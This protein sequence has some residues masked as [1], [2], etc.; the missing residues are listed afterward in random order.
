M[1][2]GVLDLDLLLRLAGA[3]LAGLA[4][5]FPYRTRPGG[6]LTHLFVTVGAAVFG[7]TATAMAQERNEDLLRV[8]QGVA[9]GIGFVGAASVLKRGGTIAGIST[10][11][12]IWIAAAVGCQAAF[13]DPRLAV[14]L[15]VL[16]ASVGWIVSVL[17]KKVFRRHRR[18]RI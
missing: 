6:V 5:G 12:S 4:L 11:A 1:I 16:I 10:A 7:T 15:A 2:R 14:V 18:V 17:E 13:G 3:A 8:I 9:S